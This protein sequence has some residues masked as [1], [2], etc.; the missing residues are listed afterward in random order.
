MADAGQKPSRD[1]CHHA[2]PVKVPFTLLHFLLVQQTGVSPPAVG[3]P[4][5][6][7]TAE[8]PACKI[9]YCRTAVCS[10]RSEE[11]DQPHIEVSAGGMVGSRS[12]NQL[13]RYGK[14]GTFEEHQKKNSAIIEL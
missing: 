9:I 13:L 5:D 1:G 8:I 11:D 2:M 14:D 10:Q 12:D 3:E 4:V 6:D 7:G